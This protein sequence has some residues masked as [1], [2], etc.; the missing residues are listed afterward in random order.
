MMC[1]SLEPLEISQGTR[2][3]PR[4]LAKQQAVSGF[5]RNSCAQVVSG[6]SSVGLERWAGGPE[7]VSSNLTTPI[8]IYYGITSSR[9]INIVKA[10]REK[11]NDS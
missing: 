10:K 3:L 2:G 8:F 11:R 1:A 4:S 7:I 6:R 5:I 9:K